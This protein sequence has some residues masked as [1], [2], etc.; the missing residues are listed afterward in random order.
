[1]SKNKKRIFLSHSHADS[2]FAKILQEAIETAT[3]EKVFRSSEE[4]A[5]PIATDWFKKVKKQLSKADALVILLTESSAGS[6]WV[7]FESGYFW[8]HRKGE[9][10]YVLHQPGV[11]VP[12]PLNNV[13]AKPLDNPGH[14]SNFFEEIC[15][16]FGINFSAESDLTRSLYQSANRLT[17]P[18]PE[19][20]IARF[21]HYLDDFR[22]WK[23]VQDFDLSG[24]WRKTIWIYEDDV[25]YQMIMDYSES[26][27]IENTGFIKAAFGLAGEEQVMLHYANLIVAG[28][29]VDKVSYIS[30][31][32]A[33]YLIPFPPL[34]KPYSI[35]SVLQTNNVE[36]SNASLAWNILDIPLKT[37]MVI[38]NFGQHEITNDPDITRLDVIKAFAAQYN[39][40]ILNADNNE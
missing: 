13:Q 5:I 23:S 29:L 27:R 24:K 7:P 17:Q 22:G 40:S 12:N 34:V 26:K 20:S 38:G 33:N 39:I 16:Q 37:A 2:E 4:H 3:G 18:R 31:Y 21:V 6:F 35:N 19:R 30:L 11:T 10:I 1:M 15:R 28:S 25:V 32:P 14:L 36:L 9:H 8:K